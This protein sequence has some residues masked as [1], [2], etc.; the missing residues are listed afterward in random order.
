MSSQPTDQSQLFRDLYRLA[1]ANLETGEKIE[2]AIEVGRERLGL[3]YGVL[4]YTGDGHYEVVRSNITTGEFS[5]GSLADLEE[6]WCRHVVADRELVAFTNADDTEYD[7]DIAKTA[8]GLRCYIGTPISIDGETYGTLCYSDDEPRTIEFDESEKQFVTLL[9][10]WVSHELERL[11]H[12]QELREQNERLD[13]FA[14][15][16]AHDL[17]NPLSTAAGF[18]QMALERTTGEANDHLQRVDRS[19]S[20]MEGLIDECLSLAEQGADVGQRDAVDLAAVATDAWD[21]VATDDASLAVETDRT[22]HADEM[23][24][25]RLFENLFRNAVEHCQ[26]DV[27]VTVADL[28]GGFTVT[29]DGPGLPDGVESALESTDA[30]QIKRLG[31]GLLVV[32]RVA[33]GHGWELTVRS[34]S[35]GTA[36]ELTGVNAA[37]AAHRDAV[38]T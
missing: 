33:S 17:R 18:T 35:D 3:K 38:D 19:L 27:S 36:F 12:H 6:T 25:R 20:R 1:S 8:T 37:P 10:D 22:V 26:P 31:L 5:T 34:S 14:K 28:P 4:S 2:Q 21:T 32:Q 30:E 9:G 29:D 16:V 13:E 11:H 23:R 24:L 7:D 15:V